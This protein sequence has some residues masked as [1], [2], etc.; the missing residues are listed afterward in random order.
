MVDTDFLFN[1][2]LPRFTSGDKKAYKKST[3]H[4]MRSVCVGVA[5][6]TDRR[7]TGHLVYHTIPLALIV[8]HCCVIGICYFLF[9]SWRW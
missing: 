8:Y 7:L 4:N 6:D 2:E 1:I 9:C 3:H 5:A